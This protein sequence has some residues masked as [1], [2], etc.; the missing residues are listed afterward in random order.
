[1]IVA[2]GFVH[3]HDMVQSVY[4][5]PRHVDVWRPPGYDADPARRY[6]VIYMHDGQNLFVPELAFAGVDWGVAP[7]IAEL[8]RDGVTQG[9][10]VVGVWNTPLR[11][12]EYMPA[13]PLT[14]PR[15][16]AARAHFMRIA[17]RLPES[18]RYLRFLVEE[19]KPLIDATYRTAPERAATSVIGSSMGGLISLYALCEYPEVFGGAGCISTHWPI[20]G[21]AL[22]DTMAAALPSPS[23]HRIYF[24]YGTE[25]IDAAYEPFQQR[26]DGRMR[27][28]GYRDGHDWQ[29]LRFDG[30][31]HNEAAWRDRIHVPLAFLL[32]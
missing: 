20:G 30:A 29:T 11:Q 21:N 4:V 23:R 28:A 31:D 6:P 27:A 14:A 5:L 1:M 22:V 3:H 32:G 26:M 16:A 12:I 10:I 15:M 18:D 13:R 2:G 25:G 24:D 17:G 9:A 8:M 7:A 19:L